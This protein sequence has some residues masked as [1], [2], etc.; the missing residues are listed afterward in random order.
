MLGVGKRM[1]S[2]RSRRTGGFVKTS[3]VLSDASPATELGAAITR[4]Q[5]TLVQVAQPAKVVLRF[6]EIIFRDIRLVGSLLASQSQLQD[7]VNFVVEHR[8]R[9]ETK[10][11]DGLNTLHEVLRLAHE[12]KIPGKLVVAMDKEAVEKVKQVPNSI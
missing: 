8:I 6:Q 5:G 1:W 3:I 7:L 11:F 12:G 10:V 4:M 9:V 2:D